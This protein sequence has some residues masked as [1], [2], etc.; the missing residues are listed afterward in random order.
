MTIAPSWRV[1]RLSVLVIALLARPL[2]AQRGVEVQAGTFLTRER[3]WNFVLNAV[4]RLGIATEWSPTW[5]GVGH[6]TGRV[7][8]CPCGSA[9]FIP[10]R[11]HSIGNGLGVGYDVQGR[12]FKRR[13]TGLVGVEWFRVLGEEHT[14]GGSLVGTAGAGVNWGSSRQW[15]TELRYGAYA[16]RLSA[17]RGRLD[18]TVVRRW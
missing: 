11:P 9:D 16:H 2:G 7:S 5:R 3:G 8:V 14:R 17:T 1:V 10:P 13:L 6:V 12:V 4:G 18:W 15:G